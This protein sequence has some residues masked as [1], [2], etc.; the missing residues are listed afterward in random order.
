MSD[1]SHQVSVDDPP[2]IHKGFSVIQGII[3]H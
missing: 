3:D 1:F 2:H